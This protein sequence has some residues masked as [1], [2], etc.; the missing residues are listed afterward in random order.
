M[1]TLTKPTKTA[2]LRSVM[3]AT[4]IPCSPFAEAK[5]HLSE[6]MT[7]VV[8]HH[9]PQVIGR[10]GGR[11]QM[12][13]MGLDDLGAMLETFRFDPRVSVS[14]G[15]F[16]VRLP[17]LNLVSG[18]VTYEE[19]IEELVELIED[20]SEQFFPRLDFYMQTDR[21]RHLPWLLRFALTPEDSRAELFAQHPGDAEGL[22]TAAA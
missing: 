13:L 14:D 6:V 3:S 8:H 22:A 20:Y 15:E 12:L 1:T 9:H 10:H 5:T 17:E 4:A 19:A 2:T 18:G 16:V 7:D 11:E 21:R